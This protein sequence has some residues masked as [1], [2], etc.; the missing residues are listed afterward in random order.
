[1][2]I[3]AA[4]PLGAGASGGQADTISKTN[5]SRILRLSEVLNASIGIR[6]GRSKGTGWTDRHRARDDLAKK[7]LRPLQENIVLRR[8]VGDIRDA[9]RL[10]DA[11]CPEELMAC[12]RFNRFW[13]RPARA[14]VSRCSESQ[15]DFRTN[16][17][18]GVERRTDDRTAA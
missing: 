9:R 13:N 15:I 4:L 14:V 7:D 11:D 3:G 10:V 16:R 8:I 6:G 5:N 2:H 12:C 1:M 18:R 17:G